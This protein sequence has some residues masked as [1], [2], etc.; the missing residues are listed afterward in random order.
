[1]KLFSVKPL[2]C[3]ERVIKAGSHTHFYYIWQCTTAPGDTTHL[4]HSAA[5]SDRM[6][7]ININL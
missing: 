5:V 2:A 4:D 7:A 3:I 1:M 6:L